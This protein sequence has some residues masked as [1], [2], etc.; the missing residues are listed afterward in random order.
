MIYFTF[1]AECIVSALE[2][3]ITLLP[4]MS[5][6]T[7]TYIGQWLPQP[8]MYLDGVTLK[9]AAIDA[10]S[11]NKFWRLAPAVPIMNES[12]CKSMSVDT[13]L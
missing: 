1:S 13:V 2:N 10:T 3:D 7:K 5:C 6:S 9:Q 4:T 8:Y 12:I 11:E